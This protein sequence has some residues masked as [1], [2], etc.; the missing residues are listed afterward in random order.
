M[1]LSELRH[2]VLHDHTAVLCLCFRGTLVN[3]SEPKRPRAKRGIV[4]E[5][6]GGPWNAQRNLFLFGAYAV[7]FENVTQNGFTKCTMS[8]HLFCDHLHNY[9]S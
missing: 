1:R 8:L 7:T 5:C 6:F 2:S 4:F 9:Q 3:E